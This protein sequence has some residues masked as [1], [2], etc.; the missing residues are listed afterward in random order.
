VGPELH[1]GAAFAI[2]GEAPGEREV[3]AERPFV[4]P[5]GAELMDALLRAGRKRPEVSLFNAVACRPIANDMG[6]MLRRVQKVNKGREKAG[7]TS[8]LDPVT[9]CRPRLLKEL[10]G[11]TDVVATGGTA[12][13]ALT[14]SHAS[15]IAMRGGLLDGH[16]VDVGD[17]HR[18]IEAKEGALVRD[19]DSSRRIRLMPTVHSSFVLHARRWTK[20]FRSD[21]ARAVRWFGGTLT[22]RE[23]VV[24]FMPSPLLLKSFLDRL[25]VGVYDVETEVGDPREVKLYCVGVGNGEEAMVVPFLSKQDGAST[26]YTTAEDIEIRRILVAW[27]TD[28]SKLKVG[29]NLYFDRQV[30]KNH[31]GV[32]PSPDIDTI[33]LHRLV[34]SELPHNLGFVV[35]MYS[36]INKSWKADHTAVT[37]E[38]DME[39]WKYNGLDVTLNHRVLTPL[40]DHVKLRNQAHIYKH[41][42]HRQ[43]L[44]EEMHHVGMFVDQKVRQR[45]E[46]RYGMDAH[47]HLI[48][49]VELSGKDLNPGSVPQLRDLLFEDWALPIPE[50]IIRDRRGREIPKPI[51]TKSGDPSTSDEAIRALVINPHVEKK[52]KAFL[53]HLRRWRAASKLIGTYIAKLRPVD[54]S[55]DSGGVATFGI[56]MEDVAAW[57]SSTSDGIDPYEAAAKAKKERIRQKQL[58]R[59]V[60]GKDGRVHPDYMA[61][62]TTMG[63]LASK[64]PNATNFPSKIRD[65]IIAGPGHK[66]VGADQDQIHMR[67][68]ASRWRLSKY[69]DVFA[70]KG[71]PHV[72]TAEMVH[73][74][75]K[76]HAARGWPDAAHRGKWW[77]LAKLMRDV[78]KRVCY[79]SLY[80]AGVETVHRVVT[81]SEDEDGNL[82]YA[83]TTLSE[84]RHMHANW[85]G[86]LPELP[87][88][89]E[90]EMNLYHA[91]GFGAEPVFGR[92]RDFLD[93][94]DKNEIVNHP[95]LAAEASIMMLVE[96]KL[97]ALVPYEYG[98]VGTGIINQCHDSLALEVPA[99]DAERVA[100]IL[101]D[102]MTLDLDCLPGVRFTGKAEIGDDWKA[103]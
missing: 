22:W 20:V 41:D 92:R 56:D 91:N 28:E 68:A 49:L 17:S 66:L 35:S 71:D 53:L 93:G 45:H 26:F 43:L 18:F 61:H 75:E 62:G 101:T 15:I 16:L 78:S 19:G 27:W 47:D 64:A 11:Y 72:L 3:E 86:A 6:M 36:E 70:K 79:S 88:G 2:V 46:Y 82:L 58:K 103:V 52:H 42:A 74:Y 48:A 51:L 85:I 10:D 23:P 7:L 83:D 38:T 34:E 97:R 33:L 9:A 60:V 94:E 1:D 81:S 44:C 96:E 29:H 63:R 40:V 65:M 21:I 31:F 73:G 98:G 14:A 77:A 30:V 76:F 55:A 50:T 8:L 54:E 100:A 69:L 4:G 59:G 89:W 102:C 13:R 99:S 87:A 80:W 25:D 32:R 5:A 24:T 37:A 95:I 57:E 84:I 39:L 90:A 67:I 12:L